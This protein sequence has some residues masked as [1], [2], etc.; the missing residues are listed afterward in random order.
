MESVVRESRDDCVRIRL[1]GGGTNALKTDVV[2]AISSAN[3]D[4]ERSARGVMLCGGD[5]L[6]EF[7]WTRSIVHLARGIGAAR[8]GQLDGARETG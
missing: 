7:E 6:K 8:N 2:R 3:E 4:A 5:P 1:S